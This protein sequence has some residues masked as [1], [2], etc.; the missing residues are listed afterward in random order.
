MIPEHYLAVPGSWI[1]LYQISNRGSV[2]AADSYIAPSGYGRPMHP[3]IIVQKVDKHGYNRVQ[4]RSTSG[5]LTLKVARL[6]AEAFVPNDD[7]GQ[8]TEVDHLDNDRRHD[9]YTN[10]EWVTSIEQQR[11]RAARMRNTG[12]TSSRFIGVTWHATD[13]RWCA[14]IVIDKKRVFIENFRDEEDAA[15]AYDLYVLSRGLDHPINWGATLQA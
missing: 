13:S 2:R 5:R 12:K 4:L 10:L 7:P 3:Q 14:Q 6:V 15:R 8:K 1:R 11:R 9:C